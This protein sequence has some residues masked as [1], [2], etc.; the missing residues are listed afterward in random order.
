MTKP[1]PP[2]VADYWRYLDRAN[3]RSISAETRIKN[4]RKAQRCLEAM[5]QAAQ[6]IALSR[7]TPSPFSWKGTE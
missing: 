5:T 6:R 7:T 1:V 3:D 2:I 4:R